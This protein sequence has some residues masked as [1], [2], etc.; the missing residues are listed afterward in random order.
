MGIAGISDPNPS[1]PLGTPDTNS[2]N[3]FLLCNIIHLVKFI[4]P[5]KVLLTTLAPFSCNHLLHIHWI[6]Y[7]HSHMGDKHTNHIIISRCF[8]YT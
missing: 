5:G 3:K 7:T 2:S 1:Q 6:S 4:Y 8:S